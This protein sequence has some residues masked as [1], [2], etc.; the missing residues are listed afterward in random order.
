MGLIYEANR[1]LDYEM[2]NPSDND[3][4]VSFTNF[5]EILINYSDDICAVVV[6]YLLNSDS[7]CKIDY[8]TPNEHG[9]YSCFTFDDYIDKNSLNEK[10]YYPVI[11]YLE[12]VADECE[13]NKYCEYYLAPSDLIKVYELRVIG[14]ETIDG[15]DDDIKTQLETANTKIK[16][17][18]KKIKNL[19]SQINKNIEKTA[20]NSDNL[21]NPKDSAYCLIA[22]L[23]NLLLDPDINAYYFKTESPRSTNQPTQDGLAN[24]INDMQIP[25]VLGDNVKIIFTEANKKLKEAN[26]KAQ[27]KLLR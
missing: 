26:I 2:L 21:L 14:I 1:K 9:G 10:T 13:D 3:V 8:Y 25:S 11:D 4:L 22:I 15:D 6:N 19:K 24:Y 5:L 20:T 27:H 18:K 12:S 16:E 23:K 7:F 17:Q